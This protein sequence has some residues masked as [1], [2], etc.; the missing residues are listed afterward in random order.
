MEAFDSALTMLA[1]A[2]FFSLLIERLL[3]LVKALYD[4]LEVQLGFQDYW[5]RSAARLSRV[6]DEQLQGNRVQAEVSKAVS[7]YLR[8]D[9]PGLEGV[10]ALS[11][12]GLRSLTVKAV[13]KVLAIMLGLMLVLGMD[14]NLLA[15][16]DVL[17]AQ[18]YPDDANVEN[19]RAYFSTRDIPAWLGEIITGVAI[20][21]GSSPVHKIISSL[22]KSR[23]QRTDKD[24]AA[25]S[26]GES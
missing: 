19:Y 16:I 9:F 2:L 22:E 14:I 5:N 1:A 10:R 7:D 26:A 24:T 23:K 21:L 6:L 20:G 17:N 8:T 18:A 11:A 3:E 13:S 15:L 25:T 12:D 4:F